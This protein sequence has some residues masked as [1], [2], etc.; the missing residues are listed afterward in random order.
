MLV[1]ELKIFLFQE[2][3]KEHY[4]TSVNGVY[5]QIME[6]GV[7]SPFPFLLVL[8]IKFCCTDELC[9]SL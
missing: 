3:K 8:Y 9:I 6:G 2:L 1:F 5:D 7:F 4:E